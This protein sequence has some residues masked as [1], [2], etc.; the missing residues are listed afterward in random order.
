M[1]LPR[2]SAFF[3]S[4]TRT[5]RHRGNMR[6]VCVHLP[7]PRGAERRSRYVG[8]VAHAGGKEFNGGG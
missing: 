3:P 8:L 5:G 1:P 4:P 2:I 7:G 6:G